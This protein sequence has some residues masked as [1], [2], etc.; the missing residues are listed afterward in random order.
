M[1]LLP[2]MSF[3]SIGIITSIS[4]IK[5]RNTKNKTNNTSIKSKMQTISANNYILGK[6]NYMRIKLIKKLAKAIIF[7]HQSVLEILNI[8]YLCFGESKIEK[9]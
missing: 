2:D 9:D 4:D 7:S 6:N 8:S 3:D 5:N 1:F